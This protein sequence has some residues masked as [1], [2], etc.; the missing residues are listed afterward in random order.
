M[1]LDSMKTVK[2]LNL[3]CSLWDLFCFLEGLFKLNSFICK[4]V[5]DIRR[6][7]CNWLNMFFQLQM[8]KLVGK[9]TNG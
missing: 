9:G 4:L 6:Y 8:C 7:K 1:Y 5:R 3:H 2:V